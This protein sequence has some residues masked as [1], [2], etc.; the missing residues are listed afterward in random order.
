MFISNLPGLS[1]LSK[2]SVETV[3]QNEDPISDTQKLRATSIT[4]KEPAL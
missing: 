2:R 4:D 1:G 3:H